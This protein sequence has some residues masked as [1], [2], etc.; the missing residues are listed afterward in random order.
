MGPEALIV[1]PSPGEAVVRDREAGVT[2]H[3]LDHGR[4][5]P[6]AGITK[7]GQDRDN[8]EE[9][10]KARHSLSSES[11]WT[12]FSDWSHAGTKLSTG[13]A[14]SPWRCYGRRNIYIKRLT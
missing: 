10:Q 5:R 9:A 7:A 13:I 8:Q 14:G 2:L 4:E 1:A 11:R 3:R 6:D 12:Y